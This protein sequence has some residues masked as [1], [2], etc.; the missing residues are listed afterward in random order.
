MVLE[1]D[2]GFG[3]EDKEILDHMGEMPRLIV[4]NKM[5]RAQALPTDIPGER[6]VALSALTGEGLPMLR[7]AMLEACGAQQVQMGEP[8]LTQV[9]HREAVRRAKEAVAEARG[10]LEQGLPVDMAT[11]GL[12]S[13]WHAL[14]EVTGGTVDEDVITRIFEKFCLGK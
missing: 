4:M 1:A 7:Q 14:G 9:R 5:D 3:P 10:V 13:A 2:Q 11:G 12:R 8:M 6:V